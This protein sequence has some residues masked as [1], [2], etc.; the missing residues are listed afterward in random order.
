MKA[1]KAGTITNK[2]LTNDIKF[3][4]IRNTLG[5]DLEINKGE[6]PKLDCFSVW[7]CGSPMTK[8]PHIL[9]TTTKASRRV[10]RND[11]ALPYT[12]TRTKERNSKF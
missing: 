11:N 7:Y 2:V 12:A 3:L 9:N 6:M 10:L 1:V 4:Y 8:V 5:I